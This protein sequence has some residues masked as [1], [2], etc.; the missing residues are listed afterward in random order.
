MFT[1]GNSNVTI[2]IPRNDQRVGICVLQ[3][4]WPGRRLRGHSHAVTQDFEGAADLDILPAM[5]GKTISPGRIFCAAN[6]LVKLT[7]TLDR[8]GWTA[9]SQIDVSLEFQDKTRKIMSITSTSPAPQTLEVTTA[10]EG[11]YTLQLTANGMPAANLNPLYTLSA[12]YTAPQTFDAARQPT[13]DAGELASATDPAEVGQWTQKFKL[14]N[15]PIHTHLLPT[16]KVLF[17]GRRTPPGTTNYPSLN[18]HSTQALYGTPPIRTEEQ[19]QPQTRPRISMGNQSI[20]SAPATLSWR[21]A[22]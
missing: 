10:T 2:T 7:L 11:F 19:S 13:A 6:S 18:Q 4:G 8:T 14:P 21:M 17:W 16:G 9:A 5:E 20:F 22:P 1:D 15:V 3:R 12:T